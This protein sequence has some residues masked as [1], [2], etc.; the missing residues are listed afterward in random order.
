MNPS[1]ILAPVASLTLPDAQDLSGRAQRALAFIR[2]LSITSPD[3]YELAADELRAIKARAARL[4]EQR[5]GITGPINRALKA[6]ND[7]FRGPS[8]LLAE[9]ER[10]LKSKML[11]YDQEQARIAAAARRKAEEA[12]AIERARLAEEAAARQREAAEQAAAA[13]HAQAE[14]DIQ[15]ADLARAAAIRAQ[16]E[17]AAAATT[18]QLVTAAPPASELQAKP[19][20]IATVATIQ[21]EVVDL[22][23]L[24]KHVSERPELL[25]L[26]QPDNVKLRAYVRGLGTA[27]ALPGVRVFEEKTMRARAA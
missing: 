6:I 24:V 2:D 19:K 10:T 12:A 4:E 9:A 17:A 20:G 8:E 23:A 15:A 21:F 26:I 14:G 27:C 16:S 25:A 3:E 11:A 1:E 18:A 22:H 5:T 7:L 13:E